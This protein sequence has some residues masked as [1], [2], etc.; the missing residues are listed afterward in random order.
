[1]M[2]KIA[3]RNGARVIRRSAHEIWLAGLGALTVAEEE[4]GK[5]FRTLVK[6][7]AGMETKNRQRLEKLIA[8]VKP[9]REDA[10][11]ALAKV[12]VGMDNSMAAVLHRLGVPTRREI[13]GLTKRVEELTRSL[14]RR[15]A[16]PRKVAHHHKPAP[17]TPAA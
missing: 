8:R 5:L 1:M 17:M 7:G 4:G 3:K 16:R 11:V 10:G 6:R 12:G 15:H 14:E 2:K 9:M 13:Q